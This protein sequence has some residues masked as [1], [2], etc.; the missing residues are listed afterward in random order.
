MEA[1]HGIESLAGDSRNHLSRTLGPALLISVGY[2]D[3][4]KWVATV[5][6]GA[7]FGYDLVLLVVLFNFSAVLYQYLSTCVGMVTGKNLA[8]VPV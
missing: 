1:V 8:Q 2:I 4:G 6:A 3:L 5:D 7:R